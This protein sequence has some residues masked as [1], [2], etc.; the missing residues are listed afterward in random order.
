M[1]DSSRRISSGCVYQLAPGDRARHWASVEAEARTVVQFVRSLTVRLAWKRERRLGGALVR[2][3]L[4]SADAAGLQDS[5]QP[6]R[7][8]AALV[9][10]ALSPEGGA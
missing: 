1:Q 2:R 5:K 3:S 10:K 9:Y 4:A 7:R 6:R 8:H